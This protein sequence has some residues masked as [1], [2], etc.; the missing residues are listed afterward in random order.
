M[1]IVKVPNV[2]CKTP[3][4][5]KILYSLKK[6]ELENIKIEKSY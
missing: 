3:E 2:C 5:R 4:T 1:E 6:D